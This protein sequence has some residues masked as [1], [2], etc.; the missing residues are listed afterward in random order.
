MEELLC[1]F[2]KYGVQVCLTVSSCMSSVCYM[3]WKL[4]NF[5]EILEKSRL[6]A[7]EMNI[8]TEMLNVECFI[9]G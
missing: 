5:E 8:L 1:K 9:R 2:I 7:T 3:I 4:W 6:K